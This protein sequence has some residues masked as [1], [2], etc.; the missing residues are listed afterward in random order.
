M[1][2]KINC[3]D[4][5][6]K[7][8]VS[9]LLVVIKKILLKSTEEFRFINDRKFRIIPGWNE[10][11]KDFHTTARKHFIL[12]KDNGRPKSGKIYEDMKVSRSDF[13][14]A[15]STCKCNDREYRNKNLLS[16]LKNKNYK[17]FWCDVHKSNK[18]NDPQ[19][20]EIDGA[21]S[22]SEI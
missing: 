9:D 12:W 15:L 16:N 4:S 6:H 13:K 14:T 18:H 5:C 1:C 2:N 3:T 8:V 7:E 11:V 20:S 19:V 21:C 22:N 10:Y 17:E